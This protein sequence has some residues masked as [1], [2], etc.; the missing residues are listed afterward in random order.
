MCDSLTGFEAVR[1]STVSETA[2]LI[3]M[4]V[5]SDAAMASLSGASGEGFL[6]GF[7]YVLIRIDLLATVLCLGLPCSARAR[8]PIPQS[9][10]CECSN[11]HAVYLMLFCERAHTTP[12]F[13][14]LCVG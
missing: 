6:L 8:E 5:V 14:P 3:E 12:A 11:Q 9:L 1:L 13:V 4:S 7:R 10:G 2:S